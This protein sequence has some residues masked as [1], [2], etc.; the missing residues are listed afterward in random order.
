MKYIKDRLK[1]PGT[2]RVLAA[3]VAG[4]FGVAFTDGQIEL[5]FQII[6]GVLLLW[7]ASVKA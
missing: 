6:S 1:E 7:E 4:I 3:G 5:A 2:Y